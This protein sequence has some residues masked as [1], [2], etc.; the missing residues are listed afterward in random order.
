MILH[1]RVKL[2]SKAYSIL[3]DDAANTLVKIRALPVDGKA[4]KYLAE[5]LSEIFRV[6]KTK[7]ETIKVYTT[8]YKT[9]NIHSR[10]S[11][12]LNPLLATLIKLQ[13]YE[14]SSGKF[15]QP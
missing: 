5:Y 14:R 7:I 15:N 4:N 13:M 2:N 6:P 11:D 9:I 12:V 10:S 1:I 8:R 3:G